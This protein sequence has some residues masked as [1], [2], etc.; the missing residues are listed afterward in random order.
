M[1]G[2]TAQPTAIELCQRIP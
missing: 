1:L 2:L